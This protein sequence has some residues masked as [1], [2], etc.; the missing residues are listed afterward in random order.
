[1]K[2]K[3]VQ[4][5]SSTLIV[6]LPANW[7]KQN[8]IKKGDEL[9]VSEEGKTL[10]I[11]ADKVATNYS[12]T[13]DI[14]KLK[15]FL[16]TRFLGRVYQKGYDK[17]FLVH[18]SPELLKVIQEKML[19]LIGYE[20]IEQNDKTC[21]IQ[22][23]SSKIELDFDN[24]LRKAFLIVKQ[25]LETAYDAYKDGDKS[26]LENLYIKDIEVNRF[27]YF[28][29]R[30]IN[31]EQ[32]V[33]AEREQQSH[34]LYYLIENLEDLGDFFKKL[35]KNL[36]LTK[37]KNKDILNLLE[38]LRDQFELSYS[39]FYKANIE[40]ANQAYSI[41][42]D[43]DKNIRD[44]IETSL[45]PDEIMALFKIKSAADLIY[46]FTTMRFDFLKENTNKFEDFH[47]NSAYKS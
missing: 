2:R 21:L 25:M 17:V 37:K 24:S 18:N 22:S 13:E 6:S 39:Y 33:A 28:L 4:H 46:N 9:D 10:V 11:G 8:G 23:I 7:V 1:M 35:A 47:E 31:R 26:T 27:T 38:M 40:K 42:T 20:I 34:I 41:F 3:I 16:V 44:V 30:Q 5:G 43:I 15:P 19:E 29:R 45:N 36:A 12:L 14:S 32:Y